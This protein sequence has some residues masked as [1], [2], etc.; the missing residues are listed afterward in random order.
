M[1]SVMPSLPALRSL[2]RPLE[3]ASGMPCT[4]LGKGP[5]LRSGPSGGGLGCGNELAA[6]E[7][8]MARPFDADHFGAKA[9]KN[10]RGAGAGQHPGQIDDAHAFER[11]AVR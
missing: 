5:G 2:N 1:L 9:G 8:Q 6:G 3:F 4:D 10:H 7:I 11:L